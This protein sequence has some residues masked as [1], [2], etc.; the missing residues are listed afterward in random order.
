MSLVGD[1]GWRVCHFGVTAEVVVATLR[2]RRQPR[3][4]KPADPGAS[5]RR[6]SWPSSREAAWG[7]RAAHTPLRWPHRRRHSAWPLAA[8]AH[9]RPPRTGA[10]DRTVKEG[11]ARAWA[12]LV[13]EIPGVLFL[14]WPCASYGVQRRPSDDWPRRACCASSPFE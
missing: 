12:S 14:A 2:C 11:T 10:A 9:S 1:A 6:P 7:R 3:R 5:V 8:L 4:V 13:K